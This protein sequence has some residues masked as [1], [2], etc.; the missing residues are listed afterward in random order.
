[1]KVLERDPNG[2]AA[3]VV[4]VV[5]AAAAALHVTVDD[6]AVQMWATVAAGVVDLVAV[7]V[8]RLKAWAPDTV[9][10]LNANNV[11]KIGELPSVPPRVG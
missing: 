11:G 1:M 7:V 6:A 2:V 10:A 3:A 8:A 5:T 9:R 4:V